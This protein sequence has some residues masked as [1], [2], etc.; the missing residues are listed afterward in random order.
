MK[1]RCTLYL[2]IAAEREAVLAVEAT[3]LEAAQTKDIDLAMSVFADDAVLSTSGEM[4][5]WGKEEI[6][7]M[8]ETNWVEWNSTWEVEKVEVSQSGDLAYT[9]TKRVATREM[10]G[11]IERR[12]YGNH[13][14]FKKQADGS[15][16]IIAF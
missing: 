4:Y 1:F 14:I 8:L 11:Q 6:K 13:K 10:E 3:F 2:S 16:K 5:F 7:K 9:F 15:W 12:I